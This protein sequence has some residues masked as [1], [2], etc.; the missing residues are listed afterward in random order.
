MS[1][2]RVNQMVTSDKLYVGHNTQ[3]TP[4]SVSVATAMEMLGYKDR[5]SVI[6]LIYQGKLKASRPTG[7]KILI[8]YDSLVKLVKGEEK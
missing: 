3:D 6:K 7:R 5:R 2:P 1:T 8:D 4:L